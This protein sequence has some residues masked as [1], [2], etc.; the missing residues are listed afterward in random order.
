MMDKNAV[1]TLSPD[2]IVMKLV[3][4]EAMIKREK[5]ESPWQ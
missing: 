2:E 5:Q 3:E 1:A 4:K